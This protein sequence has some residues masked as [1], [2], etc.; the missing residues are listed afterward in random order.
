MMG[1]PNLERDPTSARV[2]DTLRNI[3]RRS[4]FQI[5]TYE[6]IFHFYGIVACIVQTDSNEK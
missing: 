1:L 5:L 4:S 3:L 6:R 2:E